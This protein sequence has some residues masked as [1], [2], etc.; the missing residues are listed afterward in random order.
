MPFDRRF[1]QP[2]ANGIFLV[3]QSGHCALTGR[4]PSKCSRVERF[5]A[6]LYQCW[7]WSARAF[8]RRV[9][10]V[11]VPPGLEPARDP[12]HR[13][14]TALNQALN[15]LGLVLADEP[16]PG[17]FLCH[18]ILLGAQVPYRTLHSAGGGPCEGAPESC[19]IQPQQVPPTRD[20]VV[21]AT[22]S[23]VIVA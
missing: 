20:A 22:A 18:S 14:G 5:S 1:L 6:H 8:A 3:R 11:R 13:R 4:S 12:G 23:L 21:C 19:C 7:S 15:R 16:P 9:T 17:S 2:N 10:A